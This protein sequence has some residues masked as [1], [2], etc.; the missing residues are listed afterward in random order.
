MGRGGAAEKP[1]SAD[2]AALP[3][4]QCGCGQSVRT[5][6]ARFIVGHA[7]QGHAVTP[8]LGL[9]AMLAQLCVTACAFCDWR[10]EASLG[11][12]HRAFVAHLAARHAERAA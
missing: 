3:R 2:K 9:E 5:P 12:G 10:V 7:R 4:C 8:I 11:D 1:P 6:K